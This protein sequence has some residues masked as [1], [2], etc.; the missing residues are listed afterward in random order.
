MRSRRPAKEKIA[1]LKEEVQ[2]LHGLKARMLAAFVSGFSGDP[3]WL[4]GEIA[5]Q[6]WLR[7]P[8]QAGLGS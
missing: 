1:K 7:E 3:V 5:F 6:R 2:R 4:G 8:A